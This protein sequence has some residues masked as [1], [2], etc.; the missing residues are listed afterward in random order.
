[1]IGFPLTGAHNTVC[2]NCHSLAGVT[3]SGNTLTAT[4]A[5]CPQS[6]TTGNGSY[7]PATTPV[8]HTTTNM[9]IAQCQTCHGDLTSWTNGKFPNH[10]TT[11]FALTGQ[12]ASAACATCHTTANGGGATGYAIPNANCLPCHN[13]DFGTG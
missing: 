8:P 5:T 4:C 12:H 10:Q 13:T 2:A 11:G 3:L 7:N 9:P 1:A 6:V